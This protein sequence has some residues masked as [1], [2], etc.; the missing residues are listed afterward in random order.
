M[1][2][3]RARGPLDYRDVGRLG[4]GGR[5]RGWRRRRA[6]ARRCVRITRV[7]GRLGARAR[8]RASRRIWRFLG[9]LENR[10]RRRLGERRGWWAGCERRIVERWRL[11]AAARRRG[12]RRAALR[13]T[14]G[15]ICWQ[16]CRPRERA[17]ARARALAVQRRRF[18]AGNSPK[19]AEL[20]YELRAGHA[21]EPSSKYGA[22][23]ATQ[24]PPSWAGSSR[25]GK[26]KQAPKVWRSSRRL[27]RRTPGRVLHRICSC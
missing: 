24:K 20:G 16:F 23:L 11:R 8:S 13:C 3:L 25:L 10:G 2:V 18:H 7:G 14:Y 27:C 1:A 19:E 12:R 26:R 15:M 5:G 22:L 21:R 6:F 9:W 17:R 4:R